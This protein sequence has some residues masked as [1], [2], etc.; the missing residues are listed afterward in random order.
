MSWNPKQ[1][2]RHY[3][4]DSE[5]AILKEKDAV[6]KSSKELIVRLMHTD[7][8]I[9]TLELEC[10]FGASLAIDILSK[11]R[12]LQELHF[13][14]CSSDEMTLEFGC[15]SRD[16]EKL[17]F[18]SLETAQ[19]IKSL[20]FN[21]NVSVPTMIRALKMKQLTSLWLGDCSGT[22]YL[23]IEPKLPESIIKFGNLPQGF[24]PVV[25]N[26]NAEEV[27]N[28]IKDS[29]HLVNLKITLLT[30]KESIPLFDAIKRNQSIKC[31]AVS[32]CDDHSAFDENDSIAL[33]S[34]HALCEMLESNKVL[35]EFYITETVPHHVEDNP[36]AWIFMQG[37][38][39][40]VC[41]SLMKNV[42]LKKVG[43][44]PDELGLAQYEC[45]LELVKRNTNINQIVWLDKEMLVVDDVESTVLES[46][47]KENIIA[48]IKKI[49][50]IFESR[51]SSSSEMK[52][53]KESTELKESKGN[54]EAGKNAAQNWA[55]QTQALCFSG[56]S[57][58]LMNS[59]TN[60]TVDTVMKNN[61]S[62]DAGIHNANG[63]KR[64]EIN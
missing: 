41:E 39:K 26:K 34:T 29:T 50:Q 23:F 45:I 42:S 63:H 49:K 36:G 16:E 31:F 7:K 6:T 62:S 48:V 27:C 13:G 10:P 54:G 37:H 24:D 44:N 14:S 35:E 55:G 18:E 25:Y 52:E 64:N 38:F 4:S 17:F 19:N 59:S 51:F 60:N 12:S 43:I 30:I 58:S 56:S 46:Q 57:S 61:T 2:M 32:C 1:V 21:C 47:N 9:K 53:K 15:F 22:E 28:L 33:K 8:S 20:V 40:R 11:N 5:V 3:Y